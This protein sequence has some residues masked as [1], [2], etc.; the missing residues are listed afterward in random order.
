MDVLDKFFIK[1][2]YKFDKGYPDINDPKDKKMLFEIVD[3]LLES[4]A[5]EGINILKQ[6]LGFK[7]EDFIKQSS[8]TYKI[9]VPRPERFD[10]TQKIDNIENFEYDP[11]LK[12]SSI[13][14]IRYKN[15]KFLLKPV[16]A[17]GRAS[18]GTENEDILENEVNKYIQEGAQ[19]LIFNSPDT[20]YTIKDLKEIKGV[21]YDV[22]GGKKAD[23][24]IKGDK[25][26]PISIKKDNAGF[27]ESSDTR[28]KDV[29][30]ALSKKIENGDFAP[31][32]V[33]KPFVDPLGNVKKGINIMYN[34]V[35]DKK[36]TGVIVTDLP[37][38]DEEAIIFGSDNAVV[39]YKT[40]TPKNFTLEDDVLNIDVSKIIEDMKDVEKFDLE[41][42]LN[43]RHDST[44]TSTGGLRATV[45]P[46]NKLYRGDTLTGDKI[47][48]SYDEIMS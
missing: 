37:E 6:E 17:Q 22:A 8:I 26:Y 41:P 30:N 19:T 12:G 14:G 11:N 47:E 40:Y 16:G 4:D 1:Y 27:W 29:V 20:S 45:Q 9:L 44:R 21:G 5:E 46:K 24:V 42:V 7:D 48:L 34:E 33:F 25:D 39:I 18:A 38:K 13:G 43:I 36:V 3:M 2:L 28:Y 32:L 15:A 10:Y 23:V 31:E 35:E